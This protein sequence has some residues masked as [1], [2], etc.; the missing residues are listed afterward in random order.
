MKNW[1]RSAQ[2]EVASQIQ[3]TNIAT[4]SM[5]IKRIVAVTSLTLVTSLS[6]AGGN[7][8]QVFDRAAGTIG[9]AI[10][11]DAGKSQNLGNEF[12]KIFGVGLSTLAKAMTGQKINGEDVGGTIGQVTGAVIG[13]KVAGGA[14]ASALQKTI[15]VVAGGAGGTILG[16][17]I[18]RSS[19]E[20][21]TQ[22]IVDRANAQ[23][24]RMVVNQDDQ[25]NFVEG[26]RQASSLNR[27]IVY[28]NMQQNGRPT[29]V[30]AQQAGY[31]GYMSALIGKSRLRLTA[32]GQAEM[33]NEVMAHVGSKA[34]EVVKA[35]E[36][37]NYAVNKWDNAFLTGQT[38]AVKN[39][40]N[41]AVVDS[42]ELLKAKTFEYIQVR[43]SAATQ[44]YDVALMDG[45]I[46]NRLSGL[47]DQTYYAFQVTQRTARYAQNN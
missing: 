12:G 39:Q 38:P 42:Q 46:N 31:D 10:G 19:D 9:Q 47:K 8:D 17:A 28:A 3:E 15:G 45:A 18:G 11:R 2:S 44:G 24:P 30:S 7:S 43:N 1:L 32:S 34:M 16:A 33:P 37:Y 41:N 23:T 27:N 35:G 25:R 5:S 20:V 4:N 22:Q 13:Y 14:D 36:I 6:F 26:M 40:I 29:Q 21:S